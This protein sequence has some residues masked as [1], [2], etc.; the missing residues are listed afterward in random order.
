MFHLKV[1]LRDI[2]DVLAYNGMVVIK[3]PED[4]PKTEDPQVELVNI[5]YPIM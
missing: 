3:L 2:P 1:P 4:D 5:N